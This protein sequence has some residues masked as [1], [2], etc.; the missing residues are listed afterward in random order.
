MGR[1]KFRSRNFFRSGK[2]KVSKHRIKQ[3][4]IEPQVASL[5]TRRGQQEIQISASKRKLS[6]FG[7]E[8]DDVDSGDVEYDTHMNNCDYDQYIVIQVV[9]IKKLLSDVLCPNCKKPGIRFTRKPEDDLGF[10]AKIVI[11]CTNCMGYSRADYSSQR[12]GE[13]G[14]ARNAP[15]DVN[16]RSTLAFRGV[17]CGH[18][19]MKDWCGTMNISSV[20]SKNAYTSTNNKL[21]EAAL[22]T[23][24]VVSQTT[25]KIL[26][27]A[28][29]Q[30]GVT[31]D[32]N[33]ILD[34]AVSYDGTWQKRGHTSHNGAACTIDLL[35]GL[36]IDIEVL[37]NYCAKC[38]TTSDDIKNQ[39]W[40]ENH[41]TV[42]SK[43][44]NGTSGAM[45]VEAAEH[46]WKRSITKCKV[47][48]TTM[49]SDG[50]SKA[51]DALTALN[52]YG[53]KKPIEKEECINHVSKR[54]G[55][56]LRTIVTA[57]KAQ[58]NSI[59]GKGKLTQ[60][61]MKRIQN[62][63]GKAIKDHSHDV[64]LCKKRIMAILFHL[65]S[66][67]DMPK[68]VHCPEGAGSWCFWQRAKATG[69]VPG[70]HKDHDTLPPDVGSR[71]VPIFQR[72]S[73][74]KLIQRCARKKTQNPNESLHQ[75]IWKICPKSIY[76]GRRTLNTA[77]ALA[78]CQFS[79]GSTFKVLLLKLLGMEA[80]E[81]M[82]RFLKDKD[83]ER[84]KIAEKASSEAA[85]K[86]RKR[87]KYEQ[88]ESDQ[89]T[90]IDEGET[91]GAGLF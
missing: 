57:S 48:Y 18:S 64:K 51:F 52:V 31:E 46:L 3:Q 4:I 68:H 59:A 80:G 90:K 32:K 25:R 26:R 15:F 43:N 29:A 21:E 72:L 17:G 61:K 53:E 87:L 56:A 67:D 23:F 79:M 10:A 27:E 55:T 1:S 39:E 11:E 47:R 14:S 58:K 38:S 20:L 6:L 24:D 5:P 42:C 70:P 7:V 66:T 85:K 9:Q 30:I 83:D 75:L 41:A 34:I 45:E 77:V 71:L 86:H 88:I 91:Y 49:L 12:I 81:N 19:A 82:K 8:I 2:K 74:E 40:L 54:M 78:A 84:I 37:S 60:T 76:V 73:D 62:Y 16:V 22:R 44:F 13:P 35:T 65:S 50:D 36:P 28:Y 89:K 63:Y 33:G 69:N